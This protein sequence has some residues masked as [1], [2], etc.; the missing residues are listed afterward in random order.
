MKQILDLSEH[1]G[2]I[3]FA[4]VREEGYKDVIL[5]IGWIGNHNNHTLD[6]NFEKN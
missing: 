6:T 2:I 3:D 4:K 1:N 5:R